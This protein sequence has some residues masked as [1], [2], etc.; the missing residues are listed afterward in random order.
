[1]TDKQEEEEG[2]NVESVTYR[3]AVGK[4]KRQY[5]NGCGRG[6][7]AAARSAWRR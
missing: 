7:E 6:V 5:S 2:E 1:M 3:F 4:K